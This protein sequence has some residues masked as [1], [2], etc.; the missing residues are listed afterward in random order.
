MPACPEC[1]VCV[2]PRRSGLIV[3]HEPGQR[4]VR[5]KGADLC[6]GS[7]AMVPQGDHQTGS[8]LAQVLELRASA[9]S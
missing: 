5:H 9:R 4:K 7:D 1:G 8:N 6:P 2:A 3:K